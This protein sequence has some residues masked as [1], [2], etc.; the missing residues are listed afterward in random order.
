ME[1]RTIINDVLAVLM[2][3]IASPAVPAP[4]FHDAAAALRLF[5]HRLRS[6]FPRQQLSP[7]VLPSGTLSTFLYDG[8]PAILRPSLRVLPWEW[9]ANEWSR[10]KE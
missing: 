6:R 2:A 7:H 4:A 9:T 5:P 1:P 3:T 10:R 8:K